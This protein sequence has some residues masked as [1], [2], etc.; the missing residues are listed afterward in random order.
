MRNYTT[1]SKVVPKLLSVVCDICGKE[2]NKYD[3][4]EWIRLDFVGGFYS[5]LGDGDRFECD[6]CQECTKELLGKYF[7]INGSYVFIE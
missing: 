4:Q 7:K 5:I 6:I 1:V 3:L 2:T